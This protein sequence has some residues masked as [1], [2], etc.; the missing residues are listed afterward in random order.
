MQWINNITA[1][2]LIEKTDLIFY[3]KLQVFAQLLQDNDYCYVDKFYSCNRLTKLTDIL[4]IQ[5]YTQDGLLLSSINLDRYGMHKPLAWICPGLYNDSNVQCKNSLYE[6]EIITEF[7]Q[8][9]K[10]LALSNITTGCYCFYGEMKSLRNG[11]MIYQ[12]GENF[13]EKVFGL[14]VE[15]F[16]NILLN[17]K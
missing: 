10:V 6:D 17:K 4:T 3:K 11:Q 7:E 12:E 2:K 5:T 1:L 13:T 9:K 16:V 14:P 8:T 15:I